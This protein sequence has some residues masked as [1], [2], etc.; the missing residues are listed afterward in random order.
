MDDMYC[1]RRLLSGGTMAI[2]S[3]DLIVLTVSFIH[4]YGIMDSMF[5]EGEWL[6]Q[7]VDSITAGGGHV[8]LAVTSDPQEKGVN[9]TALFTDEQRAEWERMGVTTRTKIG[10]A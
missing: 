10:E 5:I 7:A 9:I 8:T 2:T 4:K 1:K 3:D 6:R